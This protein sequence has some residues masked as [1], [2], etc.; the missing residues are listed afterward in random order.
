M[1]LKLLREGNVHG[2]LEVGKIAILNNYLE[3]ANT[4]NI[5]AQYFAVP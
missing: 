5:E 1:V 3:N 4:K 2:N